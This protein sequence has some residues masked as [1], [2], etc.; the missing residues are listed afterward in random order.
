M[1]DE[2]GP[3]EAGIGHNQPQLPDAA[4]VEELLAS[5]PAVRKLI[6]RLDEID[7]AIAF[8]PWL[9]E[10]ASEEDAAKLV[11]FAGICRAMEKAIK[12][13]QT[14]A[15]EP[16]EAPL[17][18]GRGFFQRLAARAE[19]ANETCNRLHQA[20]AKKQREA[21]AKRAEE[22]AEAHQDP[23]RSEPPPPPPP[24]KTTARSAQGGTMH[25]TPSYHPVIAEAALVPRQYCSPDGQIIK[26]A[27]KAD[28]SLLVIDPITKEATTTIPGVTV[29]T[30]WSSTVRG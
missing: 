22:L 3:A 20:W 11:T 14:L 24:A 18:A 26:A 8:K 2:P 13:A 10:I 28:P 4:T 30:K 9:T 12:P 7:A 25:S 21:A 6:D 27:W 19:V 1:R 15:L 23:A 5:D 29:E 16:Y 17:K